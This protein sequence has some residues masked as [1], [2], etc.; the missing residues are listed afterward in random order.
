[1]RSHAGAGWPAKQT[2]VASVT[3]VPMRP[4]SASNILPRSVESRAK[5]IVG[6]L[7][8]TTVLTAPTATAWKSRFMRSKL[9]IGMLGSR[10][11]EDAPVVTS[12]FLSVS[13]LLTATVLLGAK[14]TEPAGFTPVQIGLKHV[15][16]AR[17]APVGPSSG[18]LTR[19]T[20]VKSTLPPGV[21]FHC[22]RSTVV[23]NVCATAQIWARLSGTET[24]GPS[25]TVVAFDGITL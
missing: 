15:A 9:R 3:Q 18:S 14:V 13:V 22:L 20:Y 25:G 10:A 24:I 17:Q 7:L 4:L 5:E 2:P 8:P 12:S 19:L 23:L 6:W 1:M 16:P 11:E 21:G